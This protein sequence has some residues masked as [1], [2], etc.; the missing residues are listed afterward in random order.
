MQRQF[1]QTSSTSVHIGDSDQKT[2]PLVIN[3]NGNATQLSDQR[4]S[5]DLNSTGNNVN[6][7]A[8]LS[9]SGFIALDKNG[10]GKINNGS[11]LFGPSTGNGFAELAK[12][13]SNHNGWIDG[14]DAAFNQ[15]K[16][17]SKNADGSDQLSSL[18]SLGIGAISLQAV[19]TPF[20]IKTASNQ[21]LGS[22]RSSSVALN[23]NGT[24]GVVQQID[25]T[26]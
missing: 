25:L 1:S 9:G 12:Y 2:D 24:A 11:E 18:A 23:E 5:F 10:D 20:E 21:L 7:N 15:L 19:S 16:V 17:W 14:S 6:I 26:T 3:F 4:F 13:D 8:P 22:V